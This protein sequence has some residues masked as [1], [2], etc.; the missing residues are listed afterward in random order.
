MSFHAK[1]SDTSQLGKIF[2]TECVNPK[3]EFNGRKYRLIPDGVGF[4]Y[5]PKGS[6][7]KEAFKANTSSPV[8]S[9]T[10]HNM[11]KRSG[12]PMNLEFKFA[13][14]QDDNN[15]QQYLKRTDF[16]YGQHPELQFILNIHIQKST[17]AT[18]SNEEQFQQAIGDQITPFNTP[19]PHGPTSGGSRARIR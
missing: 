11:C 12:H 9:T 15:G 6:A 19:Q 7:K 8:N 18:I 5:G 16:F 4:Y 2:N 1:Y 14:T 3:R 10:L 17:D 13:C